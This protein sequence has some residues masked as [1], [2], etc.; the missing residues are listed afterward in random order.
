MLVTGFLFGAEPV[1]SSS[2]VQNKL[3][4]ERKNVGPFAVDLKEMGFISVLLL[5]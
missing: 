3:G 5:A 4:R 2:T 1:S